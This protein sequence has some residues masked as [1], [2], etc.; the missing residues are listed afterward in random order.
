LSFVGL[1]L[2]RF[3]ERRFCGLLFQEPPRFTR[4]EP[5]GAPAPERLQ[6]AQQATPQVPGV[7]GGEV[8]EAGRE[9]GHSLLVGYRSGEAG[10]LGGQD[11]AAP[12]AVAG[13]PRDDVVREDTPAQERYAVADRHD[14]ADAFVEGEPQGIVRPCAQRIEQGT[15]R[16][17]LS[18]DQEVAHVPEVAALAA[19]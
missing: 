4:L 18:E 14:S 15:Q 7:E 5:S 12:A 6:V 3:A 9:R 13:G 2:L 19:P 11:T 17:A 16:I 1:F 8:G 10:A